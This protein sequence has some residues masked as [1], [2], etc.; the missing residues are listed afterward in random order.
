MKFA[1]LS[2]WYFRWTFVETPFDIKKYLSSEHWIYDFDQC[3]GV[4]SF[5]VV[6]DEGVPTFYRCSH[7]WYWSNY[8]YDDNEAVNEFEIGV[9]G[10][11]D[12]DEEATKALRFVV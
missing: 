9:V 5:W 11:E 2:S 6:M 7:E 12:L 1:R 4:T 3:G 10:R 8:G